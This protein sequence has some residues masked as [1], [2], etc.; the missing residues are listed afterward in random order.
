MNTVCNIS[1]DLVKNCSA[2]VALHPDEATDAIVDVA[3]AKR[4]PFLIVPCCVFARLFPKRALRE[5][6]FV[7]SYQDLLRFIEGK[8]EDG[9]I[10]RSKL[11]FDGA[12]TAL[13]ST[14]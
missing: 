9:L 10:K 4:V 7:S 14:F 12:N 6:G 8:A 11:D 3:V 5:G 13:W 2:I 1:H